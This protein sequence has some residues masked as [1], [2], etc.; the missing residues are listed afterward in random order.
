[1]VTVGDETRLAGD[2][3]NNPLVLRTEDGVAI[4]GCWRRAVAPSAVVVLAH[5]LTA[6]KEEAAVARMADLLQASGFDVLC[7]DARGHGSSG[8]RSAIGSLED[9]DVA[10]AVHEAQK[11]DLPIVLLGI[12]M[13][14]IAVIRYLA[15]SS[16]ALPAGAVLV[17][18][19]ARWRMR[20]SLV[21]LLTAGLTRTGPGRWAAARWLGVRI[22]PRWRVGETPESVMARVHVPVAVI[23]GRDD[24]LLA[25]A[26]GVSLERAA[27]GPVQLDLVVGMGH[28]LG[29]ACEPAAVAAVEWVLATA[30]AE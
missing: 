17:S 5:G 4:S 1:L 8:G 12:S 10:A 28:G 30:V 16:D 19:P 11:G 9:L 22:D 15:R 26:H 6:S 7:Y 3:G 29:D 21:G 20:L 18:G 13:G 25:T 2:G 23:H 24:R 14:A 27:G